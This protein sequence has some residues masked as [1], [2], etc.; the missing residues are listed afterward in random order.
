MNFA[1]ALFFVCALSAANTFADTWIFSERAKISW[2]MQWETEG[3]PTFFQLSSGHRC[4]VPNEDKKNYAL[5]QMLYA[6]QRTAN[7]HC[8]PQIYSYG[9]ETAYKLHRVIAFPD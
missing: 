2:I 6:T 5:I 9:G 7:I 8:Y 1:K 4:Y 3:S